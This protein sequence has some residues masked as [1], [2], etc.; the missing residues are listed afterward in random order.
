M[1]PWTKE[2]V[3]P[4]YLNA[5]NSFWDATMKLLNKDKAKIIY[6]AFNSFW[7]ATNDVNLA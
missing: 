6:I 4:F 7:D 1:Q 5:F 3:H 2:I